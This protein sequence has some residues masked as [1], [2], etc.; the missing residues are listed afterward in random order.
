MKAVRFYGKHDVRIDDVDEP[1]TIA[2]DEVLVRSTYCGICGTDLHE[3]TEGPIWTS[4]TPNSFSGSALPQILGHEFAGRVEAVGRS[5]TTLRPGDR[6][7]IQPQLGPRDGYFGSRN[8]AF[9]SGRGA[10]I[11]L[12]WPWGGMGEFA[13]VKDY[14]AIKLPDD[15][16]DQQGA[17]I[18]PAAVAVHAIDRS[19]LKPGGT[20]LITGAGPI[21]ALAVLA[22]RAA[23]AGRIFVSEPNP[24]RRSR[25]EQLGVGA[26]LLD[27]TT[28]SVV[29]RI[30]QETDE[31]IGVD[32]AVECAGNGRALDA[33]IDAVRAQGV[34][35]VVGLMQG[36]TPVEPFKWIIKDITIQGSLCYPLTIW[37]RVIDMIRSGL[38]PVETMIDDEIELTDILEKGFKPLLD[39]TGAMMKVLV[40]V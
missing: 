35:V 31:G 26:V 13:V 16:T 7:S 28:E 39:P 15:V 18:E 14:N 36:K 20:I 2:D 10:T 24:N 8:L 21:G 4:A 32:A 30:R 33:C 12:S 25:I 19:G 11:G 1:S 3:Y 9:L 22:A 34:V 5:V 27:P 23:G 29:D 17:L 6:V 37:P 40:R 38:F